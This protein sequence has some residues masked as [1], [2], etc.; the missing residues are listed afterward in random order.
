MKIVK[1]I[2]SILEGE[3]SVELHIY[4]TPEEVISAFFGPIEDIAEVGGFDGK[5][6]EYHLS[7]DEMIANITENGCW[8]FCGDKNSIH[9][10]HSKDVDLKTLIHFFA[11]ERGHILRPHHKDEEK[12]EMKAERYGDTAVFAYEVSTALISGL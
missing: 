1:E 3:T 2:N 7:L 9:V 11:H 12:E 4:D 6:G 8:G 10:W 5:G